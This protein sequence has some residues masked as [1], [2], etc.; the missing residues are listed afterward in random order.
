MIESSLPLKYLEPT[1]SILDVTRVELYLQLI[2]EHDNLFTLALPGI[3]M[4]FKADPP[5]LSLVMAGDIKICSLSH[6]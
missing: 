3:L 6:P 4:P 1:S 5:F 2:D